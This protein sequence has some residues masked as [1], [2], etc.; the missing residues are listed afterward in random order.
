M[1][2]T[3]FLDFYNLREQPFGATP[4]PRFLFLG[5]SHREA[6][7]SLHY[8]VEA[9]RGFVALIAPPGTGKTTLLFQLMERLRESASTAFLFQTQCSSRE[10]LRYLLADMKIDHVGD[11]LV[12]MHEKLNEALVH[13]KQSGS[14]FVLVIDE[15]QN[16]EDSVLETVRLLSN[17]ET[18]HTKLMQIVLA[19]QPQLGEKLDSPNLT[20][21]RQRIS[22]WAR[23]DPFSPEETSS[24]I[25]HRLSVAGGSGRS[26]F[27]S[28][29]RKLIAAWSGGIPRNIN[30][31]CFNALSLS[32]ASGHKRVEAATIREVASDLYDYSGVQG[33]ASA[34]T[35]AKTQP[36][37]SLL[38][39]R[40]PIPRRYSGGTNLRIASLAVLSILAGLAWLPIAGNK[41]EMLSMNLISTLSGRQSPAND[42]ARGKQ[43]AS[44]VGPET[45]LSQDAYGLERPFNLVADSSKMQ[46]VPEL[47]PSPT[48]AKS[49][50]DAASLREGPGSSG[51][52]ADAPL[53]AQTETSRAAGGMNTTPSRQDVSAENLGL[54]PSAERSLPR[55]RIARVAG[56]LLR[57]AAGLNTESSRPRFHNAPAPYQNGG[58]FF[59]TDPPGLDVFIDAKAYG[60]SPVRAV[61]PAGMHTYHVTP[62]EGAQP[63]SG[64]FELPVAAVR[65]EK[66]QWPNGPQSASLPESSQA[67]EGASTRD[68]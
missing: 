30:S 7:A 10:L 18:P 45:H 51:K 41:A 68:H 47:A 31:L 48:I 39:M 38:P 59:L 57:P 67:Q 56:L 43:G 8:G 5:K 27:S 13:I 61:I 15:A 63:A 52:K 66:V 44:P 42:S 20:Q 58:V 9:N 37:K 22:T 29:A 14:R 24:Y 4:D 40:V 34:T 23:L 33:E 46:A 21:L 25:D 12:E 17:F 55:P 36:P 2:E 62:P 19:G 64:A 32:Y 1:V 54:L 6:L 3:V 49:R 28:E 16:L 60:R 53:L 35:G 11:D 65:I 26:F 50:T